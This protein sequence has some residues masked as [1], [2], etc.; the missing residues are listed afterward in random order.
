MIYVGKTAHCVQITND[1][2]T[3]PGVIVTVL[4]VMGPWA[5]RLKVLSTYCHDNREKSMLSPSLPTG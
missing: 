3:L 1:S 2:L 5:W 4:K